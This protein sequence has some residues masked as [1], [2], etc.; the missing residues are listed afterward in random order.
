MTGKKCKAY[1]RPIDNR[2]TQ[3]HPPGRIGGR[4]WPTR[5]PKGGHSPAVAIELSPLPP[6]FYCE[7]L[8]VNC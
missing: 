2:R 8:T 7:L 6:F 4:F 5:G 1:G 3:K